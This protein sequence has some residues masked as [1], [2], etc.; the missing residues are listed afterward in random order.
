MKL[1]FKSINQ[2]GNPIYMAIVKRD[3]VQLFLLKNGDKQLAEG[4]SLRINVDEIEKH[5]VTQLI[6]AN[7]LKR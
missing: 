4:A 7:L 6:Q 5:C 3:S 1:G 2:E